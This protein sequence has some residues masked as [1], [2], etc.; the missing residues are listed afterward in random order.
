MAGDATPS[1]SGAVI[2][3]SLAGVLAGLIITFAVA[4]SVADPLDH[5]RAGL[6]QVEGGDLTVVVNVED[7]GEIGMLQSGFNQMV[8]GLRERAQ[9]QDLFGRHVGVEVAQLRS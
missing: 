2:A 7:G 5:V 9:L 1:I 4:R 8:D 6:R 3:V